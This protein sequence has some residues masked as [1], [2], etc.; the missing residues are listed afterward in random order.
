MASDYLWL[1]QCPAPSHDLLVIDESVIGKAAEIISFDPTRIT[2]DDKWSGGSIVGSHGPAADRRP[3]PRGDRRPPWARIGIPARQPRHRY[4]DQS[5]H[6][7]SG[8]PRGRAA[9]GVRLDERPRYFRRSR[10]CGSPRNSQGVEAVPPDPTR[11]ATVPQAAQQRVVRSPRPSQGRL[12]NRAPAAC[13]RGLPQDAPTCR[14]DASSCPG[15]YRLSLTQPEDLW[16]PHD[17]RALRGTARRRGVP[18]Q[19]QDVLSPV[20]HRHRPP[21]QPAQRTEYGRG[22]AAAATGN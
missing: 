3:G 5:L 4:R 2:E 12:S 18:G 14:G 1:P 11:T 19:Q 17:R 20:D 16:R 15:W 8:H 7:P 10:R 13:V 9:R 22:R 6:R 21:R